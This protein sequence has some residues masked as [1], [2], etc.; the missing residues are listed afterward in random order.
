MTKGLNLL[1][2]WTGYGDWI[3]AVTGS[4]HKQRPPQEIGGRLRAR[5]KQDPNVKN[6]RLT[7]H[8]R[9][10]LKRP[11]SQGNP[12]STESAPSVSR[13]SRA[14]RHSRRPS[15]IPAAPSSFPRRRES[16]PPSV[17]PPR[18][19][20]ASGNVPVPP[21][22]HPEPVE[23]RPDAPQRDRPNAIGDWWTTTYKDEIALAGQLTDISTRGQYSIR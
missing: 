13:H 12:V 8:Q 23:R 22:V 10:V 17:C 3:T 16:R 15:V 6:W 9:G 14:L 11:D 7:Y 2:G 20:G 1:P 18:N 21:S 5:F 4:F 19:R